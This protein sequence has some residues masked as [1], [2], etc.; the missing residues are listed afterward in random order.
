MD[1]SDDKI[2]TSPSESSEANHSKN[3]HLKRDIFLS[4]YRRRQEWSFPESIIYY[5]AMN[6]T[7]LKNPILIAD[8][9][10]Y[11]RV[12]KKCFVYKGHDSTKFSS[13]SSKFWITKKFS[14]FVRESNP[15]MVA[16]ILP[17]FYRVDVKKVRLSCQNIS[18]DDFVFLCLNV[19]RLDFNH[20]T[21]MNADGSIVSFEKLLALLPKLTYIEFLNKP[22]SSSITS[23]TA[24]ELAEILQFSKVQY[25][26]LCNLSE[27]F[28]IEFFLNYMKKSTGIRF[29]VYFCPPLSEAF[30]NRLEEM[31]DEIIE[32]KTCGIDLDFHELD[33][34]KHDKI[35]SLYYNTR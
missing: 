29:L 23:K 30:K 16:S 13:V 31:I 6:P 22:A 15:K 14:N 28:D 19:K 4:T 35:E 11:D 25:F 17:K 8:R 12:D 21:V 1:F 20:T 5:M 24:K 26:E 27:V 2:S 32:S 34:E 9:F 3:G 18:L 10:A 7:N 33:E